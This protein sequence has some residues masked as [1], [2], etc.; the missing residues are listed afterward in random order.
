MTQNI[1]DD[2]CESLTNFLGNY[3]RVITDNAHYRG[4]CEKV[5]YSYTNILLKDAVQKTVNGWKHISNLVMIRGE[6]IESIYIEKAYPFDDDEDLILSI[7]KG[8][9]VHESDSES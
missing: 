7:E 2:F 8:E 5:D 1:S 4:Y 3:I 6:S 9:V